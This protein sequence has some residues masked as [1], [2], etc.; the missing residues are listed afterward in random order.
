MQPY[1]HAHSVSVYPVAGHS[2]RVTPSGKKKKLHIL[3]ELSASFE[4]IEPVLA[5]PLRLGA[6]LAS[7]VHHAHQR[8]LQV[9]EDV[10][11]LLG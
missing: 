1:R 10:F 7:G 9:N 8:G 11:E 3:A 2:V 4:L 6:L 5:P